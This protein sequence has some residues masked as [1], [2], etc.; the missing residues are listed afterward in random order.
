MS[1]D[2]VVEV[3]ERIEVINLIGDRGNE[4]AIIE[5]TVVEVETGTD[6]KEAEVSVELYSAPEH[7]RKHFRVQREATLLE[8]LDEGARKLDLKLLP[9]PETPLD[10][11]RGVYRD[12]ETGAPLDLALTLAEFLR[13]GP[14]T[15]HFAVEL[16]LAIRINTRWRVAPTKEMTPRAILALADLSPEEYSLYY[17]SESKVPLPPDVPVHLHRG[18][19]FE[20]QRDGKYGEDHGEHC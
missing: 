11:L 20:A 2:K 18:Q 14:V 10:V 12:H 4:V 15:H 1:A 8:I 9:N 3:I 5:E 7:Q 6:H 17:P 19:C 13:E 16:V